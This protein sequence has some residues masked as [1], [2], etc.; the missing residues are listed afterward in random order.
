M[1]DLSWNL[2]PRVLKVGSTAR[3]RP[4]RA[5]GPRGFLTGVGNTMGPE[6]SPTLEVC[7]MSPKSRVTLRALLTSEGSPPP[8]LCG[9][10]W[11]S[12]QLMA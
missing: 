2:R 11:S 8:P 6:L 10:P 7:R 1:R 9:W 3:W 5:C 12:G 4:V